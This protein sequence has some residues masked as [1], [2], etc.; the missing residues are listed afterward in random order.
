MTLL[1][2][3]ATEFGAR[4]HRRLNQELVIWLTTVDAAGAPQ[5]NPVWFLWDGE[6]VLVY[7]ATT[8]HR[9]RHLAR[10]PRVSLHLDG[11]EFGRDIVVLSGTAHRRPDLPPA[12]E[13]PGFLAKYRDL[14]TRVFGGPAGFRAGHAVPLRIGGLRLRG[15]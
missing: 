11:G 1:P 13:H 12:D 7:T 5:P 8:A 15:R 9:V 2:D 3:P 14:M 6:A 4:V 10:N